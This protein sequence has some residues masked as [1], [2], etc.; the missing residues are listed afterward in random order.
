MGN[1]RHVEQALGVPEMRLIV[2]QSDDPMA[3]AKDLLV[4]SHVSFE[5]CPQL[6]VLLVPGGQGT[7][8]K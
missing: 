7:R 1:G 4:V 3:C 5:Q 6:D 2:A 8:K